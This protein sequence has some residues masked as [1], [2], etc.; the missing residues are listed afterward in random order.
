VV[1]AA[2]AH[3]WPL[4]SAGKVRPVIDHVLPMAEAA[5]AHRL[6]DEGSHVGKI[7]LVNPTN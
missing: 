2:R 4:I 7:L 1:A 3:A 6:F 5:Q